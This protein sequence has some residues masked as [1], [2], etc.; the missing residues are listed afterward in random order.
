MSFTMPLFLFLGMTDSN[1]VCLERRALSQF[2]RGLT[3]FIMTLCSRLAAFSRDESR[4]SVP[5][6]SGPTFAKVA[7]QL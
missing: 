3:V 5:R 6:G 2:S 7:Q 1:S 4:T